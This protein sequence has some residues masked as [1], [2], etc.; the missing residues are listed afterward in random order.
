M[1]SRRAKDRTETCPEC[2]VP[3]EDGECPDCGLTEDEAFDKPR[4][5]WTWRW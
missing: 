1:T 2:F 4:T 5:R 3:F